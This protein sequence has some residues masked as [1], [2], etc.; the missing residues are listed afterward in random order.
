MR[1]LFV[2]LIFGLFSIAAGPA[3]AEQGARA[4]PP[5]LQKPEADAPAS[6][7]PALPN[8]GESLS[9]KLDRGDGVIK[10]PEGVDPEIKAP[11][12]DP[13]AGASMPVIRPPRNPT[14]QPK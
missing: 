6:T 11:P 13:S 4:N 3:A 9:E 1:M 14:V 7:S 8:S 12:K 2:A 10:P 5:R